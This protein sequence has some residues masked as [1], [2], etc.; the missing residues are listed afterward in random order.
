MC[1]CFTGFIGDNCETGMNW[2]LV[3]GAVSNIE[4]I[5]IPERNRTTS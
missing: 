5:G 1:N 3:Y 4:N 2:S